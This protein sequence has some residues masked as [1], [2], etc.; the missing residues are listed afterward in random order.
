[1]KGHP[2]CQLWLPHCLTLMGDLASLPC[3]RCAEPGWSP[4]PAVLIAGP[5]LGP[6]ELLGWGPDPFS[7]RPQPSELSGL[8]EGVR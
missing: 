8:C 3:G 2:L 4:T 5:P 1:M 7:P 6:N